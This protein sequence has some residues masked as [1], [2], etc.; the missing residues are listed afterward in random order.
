MFKHRVARNRV[1]YFTVW[2][3]LLLLFAYAVTDI[4]LDFFELLVIAMIFL[5]P[6]RIVHY[7]WRDFFQARKRLNQKR[8]DEAIAAFYKFI[9]NVEKKPFLKWL[10][11]FSYGLY[12][13]KVE[14]VALNYLGVCYLHQKKLELA[15]RSFH[16]SLEVDSKYIMA[17]KHLSTAA[18]LCNETGK[19]KQLYAEA[20]KHGFPRIKFETFEKTVRDDYEG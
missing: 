18:I 13:F 20:Q 2:L 17:Y 10:M 12:S 6:G 14:A 7:F 15:E 16:K 9:D 3:I 4:K 5:L 8:Y 11:F 19:A 1:L